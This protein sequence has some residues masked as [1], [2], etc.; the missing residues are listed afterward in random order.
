MGPRQ[1]A[2]NGGFG[3]LLGLGLSLSVFYFLFVGKTTPFEE[4]AFAA[5][6]AHFAIVDGAPIHC[7]D[8]RD[9]D[10]CISPALRVK[11][12][13]QYIWLGNSQLHAI[14]QSKSGDR[15]AAEIL[16]LKLRD[17][18]K[19]LVAFSEPSANFQ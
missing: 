5:D 11:E 15:S 1:P 2:I 14:N 9:A 12:R 6:E 16:H 13:G 4:A 19:Y 18:G 7:K 17:S 3:A 10:K 8:L